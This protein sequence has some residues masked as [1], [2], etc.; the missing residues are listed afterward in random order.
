MLSNHFTLHCH[1]TQL[2]SFF[3]FAACQTEKK[4]ETNTAFLL[5]SS[6]K[7][8]IIVTCDWYNALIS[9]KVKQLKEVN[10]KKQSSE[11]VQ[12]ILMA[13]ISLWFAHALPFNN[14]LWKQETFPLCC[15]HLHFAFNTFNGLTWLVKCG[16]WGRQVQKQRNDEHSIHI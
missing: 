8:G 15:C 14:Y 13:Y 3:S 4:I 9:Y 16:F 6:E 7:K 5:S 12:W 2:G 11:N 1:P 10:K